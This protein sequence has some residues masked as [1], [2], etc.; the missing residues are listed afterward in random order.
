MRALF[1]ITLALTASTFGCSSSSDE[2]EGS[3]SCSADGS[4]YDASFQQLEC[5]VFALVNERR[6]AGATCNGVKLGP[7]PALKLHPTLRSVARGH[8]VDMSERNYFAHDNLEGQSPFDRMTAAGYAYEAAAENIAQGAPTAEMAM[9]LWMGSKDGHCENIM[10]PAYTE[11]GI[12][13]ATG[14]YWVQNFGSSR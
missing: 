8:A 5:D 1:L 7:A 6:T 10:N 11:F 13:Y 3:T 12:G 2:D 9:N 4:G 14:H